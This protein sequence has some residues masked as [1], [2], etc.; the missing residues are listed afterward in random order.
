[1]IICALLCVLLHLDC[2]PSHRVQLVRYLA[3]TYPVFV[4]DGRLGATSDASVP[5][6]GG[7]ERWNYSGMLFGACS[8]AMIHFGVRALKSEGRLPG[9][10]VEGEFEFGRREEQ[11]VI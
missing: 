3:G 7:L 1:M 2:T 9:K 6:P 8:G 10:C 11:C 4:T 5:I